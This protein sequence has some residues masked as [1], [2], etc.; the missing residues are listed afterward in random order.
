M[1]KYI[2]MV[3]CMIF[4]HIID[5]YVLQAPCLSN[6]KQK[7]WW[8]ENAPDKLYKH[9]YI[10][11]LFMHSFSWAFSILLPYLLYSRFNV[12]GL[13]IVMLVSNMLCHAFID[14][15]KANRHVINLV[16]DQLLHIMQILWTAF[17]LTW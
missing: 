14:D 10:M 4:C 15:I 13:Y 7:S 3:A 9:D 11:A 8:E 6:L 5:D 1:T 17:V 12:D 2:T 16:H